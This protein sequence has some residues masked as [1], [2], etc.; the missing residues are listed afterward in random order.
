MKFQPEYLLP[1]L[2]AAPPWLR[3]AVVAWLACGVAIGCYLLSLSYRQNIHRFTIEQERPNIEIR[4]AL[5]D[6]AAGLEKK[7][8][9][10]RTAIDEL[11]S[12][13]SSANVY[14]SGGHLKAQYRLVKA[15][16]DDLR[17]AWQRVERI[18]Q[19]VLMTQGEMMIRDAETSQAYEQ[20]K[21]AGEQAV[22]RVLTLTEEYLAQRRGFTQRDIDAVKQEVLF[23]EG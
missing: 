2:A 23:S 8:E 14:W 16:Q 11:A 20:A 5:D 17:N 21:R 9:L 1:I 22:A 6:F 12:E 3:W 13:W 18:V 15:T 10:H 19:D 4:R 7:V